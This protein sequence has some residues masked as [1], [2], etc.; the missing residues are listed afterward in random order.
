MF[1]SDAYHP[2]HFSCTHCRRVGPG[3]VQSGVGPPRGS[4]G[5]RE[6]VQG[7]D[8][9][10]RKAL[11]QEPSFPR[12]LFRRTCMIRAEPWG[13]GRWGPLDEAD[14][15]NYRQRARGKGR[16]WCQCWCWS[17][18]LCLSQPPVW[19]RGA[20]TTHLLLRAL[21]EQTQAAF[22][23]DSAGILCLGACLGHGS[24]QRAQTS[25]SHLPRVLRWDRV[26]PVRKLLPEA[27]GA[28]VTTEGGEDVT[29]GLRAVLQEGADC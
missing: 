16:G 29:W 26:G 20:Q 9:W 18:S 6:G 4:G 17:R 27:G 14:R 5:A 7:G 1:K 8:G 24:P 2:D 19:C 12:A 10:A 25:K 23:R 13:W 28:A 22:C 11:L 15:K 21:T 3:L